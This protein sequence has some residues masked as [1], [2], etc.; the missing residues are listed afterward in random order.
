MYI[1]LTGHSCSGKGTHAKL[2]ESERG[3]AVL[4][5][6]TLLQQEIDRQ[7]EFGIWYGPRK[8]RGEFAPDEKVLTLVEEWL[9][10]LPATQSVVFDGFPRSVEQAMWLQEC[11]RKRGG[12][13]G[14]VVELQVPEPIRFERMSR[15]AEKSGRSDDTAEAFHHR[16]KLYEIQTAPILD[17]Y[18]ERGAHVLFLNGNR[19]REEV[20]ADIGILIEKYH[21]G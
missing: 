16:S 2:L 21:A 7:T 12:R 13:V 9:A 10:L 18:R 15:R 8:T 11:L 4:S 14:V 1:V 19:P 3:M 5:T 17:W 6:G 20:A